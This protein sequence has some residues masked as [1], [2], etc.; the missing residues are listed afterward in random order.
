[1]A[2]PTSASGQWADLPADLLRD[3]SAHLHA[4]SDAVRFHAVCR[5]WCSTPEN[6]RGL[7][8]WLV[9]PSTVDDSV[10]V[11]RLRPG[12]EGRPHRATWL[13]SADLSLV[14]PLNAQ[15]LPFPRERLDRKW[16]DHR[17]R[18]VSDDDAVLLYDFQLEEGN[19]PSSIFWA[20][21]L[22][23]DHGEW[24]RVTSN[25]GTDHCCA[26]AYYYGYIMCVGLAPCHI[27][28][29]RWDQI[30]PGLYT[31]VIT[32]EVQAALP[33]E[34]GK[35]RRCGY[36][37]E[38][39]GGL[40][41]ASV[42]QEDSG[43][44]LSVSLHQLCLRN[45]GEGEE[46]LVVEWV[47]DDES[48]FHDAVLFLGFPGIFL[49]D[50]VWFSG[51]LSGGTAYFVI[52]N[53]AGHDGHSGLPETCSV[54]RYN[55]KDG[56]ATLVEM[57]PPG[58]TDASK[59]GKVTHAKVVY[60]KCGRLRGFGFVTMATQKGF[61]KAMAARNAVEWPHRNSGIKMFFSLHYFI[62]SSLANANR[63]G[64]VSE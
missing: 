48:D 2:S 30:Y 38:S 58:W 9:A 29:P 47:R 45:G 5:S 14:S 49:V 21:F 32:N 11:E 61:N 43:I 31:N 20:S 1:M 26:A 22:R 52:D 36:L 39:G 7:L 42:L 51:E 63:S 19:N 62:A 54:Y 24:Q 12:H 4:A 18:I 44:G 33:D 53:T 6:K 46:E 35:V 25:L 34:P 3:I 60:D 23:P 27:L 40:L 50:A 41:L 64:R 28:W 15:P 16:L 55:F 59:H 10:P 37:F 8:P 17:R 57:L 56:A 13:L